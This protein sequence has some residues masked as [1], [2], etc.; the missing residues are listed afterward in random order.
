MESHSV[1]LHI[2][3]IQSALEQPQNQYVQVCK[4]G[5][6]ALWHAFDSTAHHL[7]TSMCTCVARSG[8][9]PPPASKGEKRFASC[10]RLLQQGSGADPEP[11]RAQVLTSGQQASLQ[12]AD[13]HG[14]SVR[15]LCFDWSDEADRQTTTRCRTPVLF[16]SSVCAQAE[17]NAIFPDRKLVEASS[18]D[19]VKFY[20]NYDK[21]AICTGSQVWAVWVG[22]CQGLTYSIRDGTSCW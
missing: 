5:R 13:S 12:A 6:L 2:T 7:R 15:N 21:L 14:R 1:A 18:V 10:I 9:D 22:L 17:A 11:G 20:V 8:A 19:G 4:A 3:S 16:A